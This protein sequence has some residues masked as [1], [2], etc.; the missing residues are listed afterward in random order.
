MNLTNKNFALIAT[1]ILSL[2]LI[3]TVKSVLF[4]FIFAI[5]IA[6][7]CNPLIVK[8][9][10]KFDLSRSKATILVTIAFFLFWIIILSIILPIIF[11]Q[12]IQLSEALPAYFKVIND[13]LYPYF[14]SFV[15]L[16][17]VKFNIDFKYLIDQ[18]MANGDILSFSKNI[19]TNALSSSLN[20]IDI[21]IAIFITPI[22]IFYF[23]KDWELMTK[24]LNNNLPKNV[25][26]NSQ[27]IF[28]EINQALLG[29]VRGEFNVCLILA[30]FYAILLSVV[31]LN[32]GFLIGFL[33]GLIAFIPYI[34]AFLSVLVALIIALFQWGLDFNHLIIIATIFI[35]G[36]LIESNFLTPKLVGSKIGLHPLWII[37]GLFVFGKLLGFFGIL[38][39]VPLTAICGVLVKF[40]IKAK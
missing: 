6:Y 32:F 2:C 21:I 38:L 17:G 39:A 25:A 33:A 40:I 5:I 16:I 23:L 30:L 35:I 22:L 18:K 11:E 1:G 24:A 12:L 15:N 9:C 19:L 28:S 29:Y 37:L 7:F 14:I 36:N 34:G 27:K 4:P 26:I 20:L 13:R 31:G 8:L 10:Q 3:Y